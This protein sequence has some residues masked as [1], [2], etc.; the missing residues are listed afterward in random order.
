MDLSVLKDSTYSYTTSCHSTKLLISLVS[1]PG[2]Q[3]A[4][5]T[6]QIDLAGDSTIALH[7]LSPKPMPEI[8]KS[9]RERG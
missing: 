2:C 4:P 8:G 1:L 7:F 3:K 9:L 6:V 5:E